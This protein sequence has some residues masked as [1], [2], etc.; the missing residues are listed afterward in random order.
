MIVRLMGN[1]PD[2]SSTYNEP[3]VED[4]SSTPPTSTNETSIKDEQATEEIKPP[5]KDKDTRRKVSDWDEE[6]SIPVILKKRE[7]IGL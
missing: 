2:V 4:T 3:I 7:N 1:P 5:E 6:V